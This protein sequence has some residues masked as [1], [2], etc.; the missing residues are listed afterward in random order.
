MNETQPGTCGCRCNAEMA[1]TASTNAVIGAAIQGPICRSVFHIPGMDCPSEEQMIRLSLADAQVASMAFDLPGRTLVIDHG[2]SSD[3]LLRHLEPLGYGARL[4]ESRPLLAEDAAMGVTDDAAE[5]RV[6]WIL[7]AINAAMFVIEM[8][9]GWR[10]SSA[11]L[12]ADAA[13]MLTDAAVY[14]VALYAVGRDAKDKLTAA[15]LAGLLQLLLALGALTETGRRVMAGSSPEGVAMIGISLLAL[16]AN[17]TCL[18]LISHHR[19]GGVHMRASYI[20]TANDVLAN[21][22]VIVAGLA[23]TWTASPVP[24][25]AIGAVIG[26]MVLVGAVRI[27]R[28]K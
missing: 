7:L 23:V 28:L 17:V 15:K 11:G 6:L 20:F 18:A 1:A 4:K 3:D 26:I 9:A 5:S 24:D 13:D 27:L 19:E 2:G 25:W 14:G 21:L 10:A 22:G 12:I 16:A 8:I